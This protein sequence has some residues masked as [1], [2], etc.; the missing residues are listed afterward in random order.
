M[1]PPVTLDLQT[2]MP[3]WLTGRTCP[4]HRHDLSVSGVSSMGIPGMTNLW[5]ACP[6]RH[7]ASLPWYAGFAAVLILYLF[8]PTSVS[9][10]WRI[11]HTHTWLRRDCTWCIVTTRKY[12]KWNMFTQIGSIAKCW[13]DVYHCGAGLVVIGPIRDI[14]QNVIQS[15]FEQE[16]AVAATLTD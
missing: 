11:V 14:G 16:L 8:Y 1:Y 15:S 3:D 12:N 10:L 5:H 6:E 7:E 13:L 4:H 2:E 9:V